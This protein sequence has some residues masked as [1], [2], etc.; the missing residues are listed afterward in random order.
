MKLLRKSVVLAVSVSVGCRQVS[1]LA[2][3]DRLEARLPTRSLSAI[4]TSVYL[5][6]VGSLLNDCEL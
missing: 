6:T 3:Q 5:D 4:S 1:T 2:N